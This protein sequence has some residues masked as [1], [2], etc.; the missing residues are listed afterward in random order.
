MRVVVGEGKLAPVNLG[1]EVVDEVVVAADGFNN[2]D[3]GG[4]TVLADMLKEGHEFT[5]QEILEDAAISDE[6]GVGADVLR[7]PFHGVGGVELEPVGWRRRLP[8]C[9]RFGR[10]RDPGR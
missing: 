1:L 9:P 8:C 6:E 7:N 2:E 10:H 3:G 5:S 4:G